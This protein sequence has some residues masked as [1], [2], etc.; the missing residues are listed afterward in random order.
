[1]LNILRGVASLV[2]FAFGLVNRTMSLSS[3]FCF[4]LKM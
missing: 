2:A 3:C 1:M 4:P